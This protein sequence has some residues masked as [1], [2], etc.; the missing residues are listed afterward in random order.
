MKDKN[1]I[2]IV[3]DEKDLIEL[4]TSYLKKEDYEVHTATGGIEAL[5][6]IRDYNIDLIVLDV[7]M[8]GLD[9]F[10]L[11]KRIREFSSIPI[12]MLTARS[13][14]D[15]KIHGLRTGADDYIVKPFS[16]RELLARIEAALRRYNVQSSAL[17]MI[18]I[19][20]L[21]IDTKG[22]TVLVKGKIINMTKKEFELLLFL[23]NHR[24]QVFTREHLHERI[25][26][27]DS[28][29]GTLRTVDT[30]IKTVRLKLQPYDK[31]IKTIWGV[32]YKFEDPT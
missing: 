25:W 2:L 19:K 12:I 6:V 17:D 9:G 20:E 26:G 8:H 11:L 30:H 27:M 14:E 10:A 5:E 13:G 16:P 15:D 18:Q 32:G 28:Q 4:V 23:I 31:L 3:D 24:G 7:M 21:E 22:R 29:K 1:S